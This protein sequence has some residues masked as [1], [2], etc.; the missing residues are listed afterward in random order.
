[1]HL[2]KAAKRH[3]T[4]LVRALAVRHWARHS[5]VE[6]QRVVREAAVPDAQRLLHLPDVLRARPAAGPG[7]AAQPLDVIRRVLRARLQPPAAG[8]APVAAS[9]PAVSRG[10]SSSIAHQSPR[11]QRR[12][13][14][15]CCCSSA[16]HAA[17]CQA[18]AAP[19]GGVLG[20][21]R[22]A[23]AGQQDVQREAGGGPGVLDDDV[24]QRQ[25][26]VGR[27]PD[28]ALQRGCVRAARRASG[29]AGLGR[30]ARPPAAWIPRRDPA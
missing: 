21:D 22:G 4:N 27:Q 10:R 24:V 8:R 29:G 18:A 5:L 9:R 28:P 26:D 7:H 15:C 16:S 25:R 2:P 19:P 20:A 6:E 14:P 13:A 1:M 17:A 3:H 12:A 30:E 23:R 11:C